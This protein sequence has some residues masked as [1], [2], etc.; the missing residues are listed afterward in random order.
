MST[1]FDGID[2]ERFAYDNVHEPAMRLAVGMELFF[3]RPMHRYRKQ[4]L[5]VWNRFL[6]WRGREVM[7]WARLGGG[8]KSRMM[9]RAA[10]QTIDAWLRGARPY[11][12]TCFITVH[13]GAWEQMGDTAFR[14]EGTDDELDEQKGYTTLN[15][16]QIRVPLTTAADSDDLATHL[17]ELAGPLELVCGTAGLMLHMTPFHNNGLW[18]EVKGL[19]TRFEGVEPDGVE[20]SDSRAHFGLT[21]VNWLTFVGAQ[22]LSRL[23][24]IDAV[25]ARAAMTHHV[26]TYRLDG[27]LVLR[28]GQAPRLGDR[29]KP[30]RDLDPY[31][32]AY[33]IVKSAV[34]LDPFHAISRRDFDG[35]ATVEWLRRFERAAEAP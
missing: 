8:N 18:K 12:R 20:R 16:V 11:G 29:N 13:N 10:Y 3:Q 31:R 5:E 14:V 33:R 28:A 23:G 34:L 32:E 30:S 6:A 35:D 26:T 19:V 24:G 25:E 9:N 2:V 7:T 4:V 1:V 27:T 22:H 15:F 21:G 17:L